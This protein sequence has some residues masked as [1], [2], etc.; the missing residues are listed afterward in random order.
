MDWY[1]KAPAARNMLG[2]VLKAKKRH[3]VE[4]YSCYSSTWV[5][6]QRNCRKT[7][8]HCTWTPISIGHHGLR[9]DT[10]SFRLIS[11]YNNC[12]SLKI[13]RELLG[14]LER[15]SIR[16]C[17]RQRWSTEVRILPI[18]LQNTQSSQLIHEKIAYK[19]Q[20]SSSKLQLYCN[21][22]YLHLCHWPLSGMGFLF[23]KSEVCL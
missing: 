3:S 14:I 5:C 21:V 6:L 13:I 1:T 11:L 8:K 16:P 19:D 12:I 4:A 9:H 17:R 10:G 15:P 20:W 22:R 7:H 2:I 18:S 23:V